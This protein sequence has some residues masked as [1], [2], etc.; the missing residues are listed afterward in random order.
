MKQ[1]IITL[2]EARTKG[3]PIGKVADDKLRAIVTEVE[4]TIIRPA[5]GDELYMYLCSCTEDGY[6]MPFES[7]TIP[8]PQDKERLKETLLE[9]GVYTIN[10]KPIYF[11]GLKTTEAYFVYAQIVMSGDF[12]SSRFGMVVKNGDYSDHISNKERSD[13]YNQMTFTANAYLGDC[14]RFC[15]S[16][17]IKTKSGDSLHTTT[18]CVIHKIGGTRR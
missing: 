11:V 12:E 5:L 16:N 6:E 7:C 4:Q 15:K 17:R 10:E 13:L 2:N 18:G 3:R 8:S 9:G 1:T 14:V